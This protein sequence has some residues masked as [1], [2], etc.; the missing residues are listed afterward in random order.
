MILLY[1]LETQLDSPKTKIVDEELPQSNTTAIPAIID[2][3]SQTPSQNHGN[4][5]GRNH[6]SNRKDFVENEET[7][8]TDISSVQYKHH[9]ETLSS[10]SKQQHYHQSCF[11]CLHHETDESYH[12]SSL[13]PESPGRNMLVYN[14]SVH[15]EAFFKEVKLYTAKHEII[16]QAHYVDHKM[17]S[18]SL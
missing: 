10:S 18:A 7:E 6:Q 8:L 4:N 13:S 3:K 15:F 11:D 2:K 1:K 12:S 17:S 9:Q 5:T 14:F 16:F